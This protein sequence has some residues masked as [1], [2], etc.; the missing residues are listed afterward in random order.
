[1]RTSLPA[2]SVAVNRS[3]LATP[4]HIA[5]IL[6]MWFTICCVMSMFNLDSEETNKSLT[7]T[8]IYCARQRVL[9]WVE[10][11]PDFGR[12]NDLNCEAG[13]L[14]RRLD[15]RS[16]TLWNRLLGRD[17]TKTPE[18]K[19]MSELL[20]KASQSCIA[21]LPE[22]LRSADLKPNR[23]LDE[24]RIEQE[25]E[26]LVR[27]VIVRR[28]ELLRAAGATAPTLVNVNQGG[29]RML[30]YVPSESLFDGAAEVQSKGFFDYDNAPPWDT[31]IAYSDRTLLSWVPGE[32][33]PLV[34]LGIDVN[35]EECIRWMS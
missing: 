8:M 20:D 10:M 24:V 9:S 13:E 4:R 31:W 30:T 14:R 33:V 3:R 2:T 21:P 5:A 26:T 29:G 11:A 35:P 17:I 1:M 25:R 27:S 19:R 7:E 34:Q 12:R 16:K 6:S 32:L 23:P 15:V 28:S 22:L 18:W